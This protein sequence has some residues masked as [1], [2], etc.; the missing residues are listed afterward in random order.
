MPEEFDI[1]GVPFEER[2]SWL[3]EFLEVFDRARTSGRVA[4]DGTYHSFSEVGFQPAPAADRP[5]VSIGGTLGPAF[6]RVAEYGD[7]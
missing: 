2:V 3:D 1:F 6:R 4:F 7:G 5:P